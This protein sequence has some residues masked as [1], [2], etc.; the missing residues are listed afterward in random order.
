MLIPFWVLGL[1]PAP[2]YGQFKRGS[3]ICIW[4]P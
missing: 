2:L 4:H 3:A 1:I